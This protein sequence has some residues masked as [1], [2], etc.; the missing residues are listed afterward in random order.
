MKNYR[1]SKL[2]LIRLR[3]GVRIDHA[4]L[5]VF[6][7]LIVPKWLRRIRSLPALPIRPGELGGPWQPFDQKVPDELKT[8]AGILRYPELEQA[9]FEEIQLQDFFQLHRET[10]AWMAPRYWRSYLPVARRLL[11]ARRAAHHTPRQDPQ[12]LPP[13]ADGAELA[14]RLKEKALEYG[15]SAVGVAP[16][17]PKYTFEQHQGKVAGDRM[18]VCVLE[19][20]HEP[21]QL[22]PSCMAENVA[23]TTY[24]ELLEKM[25]KLTAWLQS[26]GYKA[27]CEDYEGES[28]YIHYGV[29]AGLGQLGLNGQLLTPQAGSRCRLAGITTNAPLAF[30]GPVDYGIEGVCDRCQICA[31]RCPAGAI[32]VN[33]K[34]YRGVVKPKLNTKRCLPLVAQADGCAICMKVCPV[35]AFGLTGVIEEFERTGKILG[36]DTDELEGYDWPL[37]GRHYAPGERPRIP[38][39]VSLPQDW[40]FDPLRKHPLPVAKGGSTK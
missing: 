4:L 2:G 28:I 17:D 6:G 25:L 22:A 12:T 5:P 11:T 26:L 31:R 30:D 18:V 1:R 15:L 39:K 23:L 32:P 36:K 29:Q 37:D 35:Q 7:R 3:T 13:P 21:T 8:Q 9:A 20:P 19:Q 24:A 40:Q 38:A 10:M 34:E 16:Y 33:R 14:R 27:R